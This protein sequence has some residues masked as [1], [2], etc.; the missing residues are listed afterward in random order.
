M[1][2]GSNVHIARAMTAAL[3]LCGALTLAAPTLAWATD[4]LPQDDANEGVAQQPLAVTFYA[5]EIEVEG[6]MADQVDWSGAGVTLAPCAYVRAGY[7]FRA[8]QAVTASGTVEYADGATIPAADFGTEGVLQLVALWEPNTYTLVF[9]LAGGVM[10]PTTL[11]CTYGEYVTYPVPTRAGYVF[12]GW[13]LTNGIALDSGNRALLSTFNG[14]EVTLIA[15]WEAT[16]AT[17]AFDPAYPA[18][19]SGPELAPVSAVVGDARVSLPSLEL[20]GYTFLGWDNGSGSLLAPGSHTMLEAFGAS[21]TDPATLTGVWQPHS[22]TLVCDFAGGMVKSGGIALAASSPQTVAYGESVTLPKPTRGGYV[23]AGWY[24]EAGTTYAVGADVSNLSSEDGASVKLTALW[25]KA[26]VPA[27]ATPGAEPSANTSATNEDATKKQEEGS[28]NATPTPAEAATPSAA[29]E[30]KPAT[31]SSAQESSSAVSAVEA[32]PES[33]S[34]AAVE[35]VSSAS[36]EARVVEIADEANATGT[37]EKGEQNL[38]SRLAAK[39]G[40]SVRSFLILAVSAVALLAVSAYLI[41]SGRTSRKAKVADA[42]HFGT[43]E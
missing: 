20:D 31:T 12:T 17:L 33:S 16:T 27:N 11:A 29:A 34:A 3:A 10:E 41:F 35:S 38:V 43:D 40:I 15:T 39:L 23:L 30:S 1:R 42:R 7:H 22:Y 26:A 9:D 36:P 4:E 6:V 32:T 14:D 2:Q 5:T 24:D 21:A 37:T 19:T 18:G 28:A 8:W 25:Q 13:T